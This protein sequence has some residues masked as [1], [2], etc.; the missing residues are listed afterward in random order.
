MKKSM[1]LVVAGMAVFAA[2]K[3]H[4]ANPPGSGKFTVTI[5]NV[6]PQK[7]FLSSGVFNT[8]VGASAPGAIKPGG[9]YEFTVTSGKK[10]RLSFATMLAAT[11]DIFFA[12]DEKGISLYDDNGDPMTGEITSQVYLWDAGTEIN[13]EPA[14]GPN[15]VTKQPAPNTGPAENG[16]VRKLSTVNDGF[17][18]P[19]VAQV[20]KVNVVHISGQQFKITIENVST[21]TTLQT[22]EGPKAAPASPGVWVI[23]Q[24]MSP[25][26]TPG[27]PDRGQGIEA[28]AEDGDATMLGMYVA[29]NSGLTYP[30][31]PG[32]WAVHKAGEKTLI[33]Q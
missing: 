23:F 17:N 31:S 9:K 24:G 25:L 11:N 2:C 4:D 6:S 1:M 19:T 27:K 32:A 28:I 5:E 18:Y 15:T 29:D 21:N 3:K 13:E 16:V 8:P 10:Q 30:I 14:V 20:I 33:Y 12:P 22:S 7:S 26:F